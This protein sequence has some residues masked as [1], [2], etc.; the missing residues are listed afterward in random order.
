MGKLIPNHRYQQTCNHLSIL[1]IG[2]THP[3]PF[4][5]TAQRL[6]HV[7]LRVLQDIQEGKAAEADYTAIMDDYYVYLT[8][9]AMA[10]LSQSKVPDLSRYA[11]ELL[12]SQTKRE[13]VEA[14]LM[15]E[16]DLEE[17]HKVFSIP[18]ECLEIY[19]DLFFDTRYAFFSK[20]DIIEY[21][22]QYPC[23]YG[24]DLKL[25]CYHHGAAYV[26]YQFAN[27]VPLSEGQR[28]IIKKL[29]ASGA[30]KAMEADFNKIN[31]SISKAAM[32]WSKQTMDAFKTI[33]D[34]DGGED[35]KSFDS[36]LLDRTLEEEP[37]Y[38]GF[39]FVDPDDETLTIE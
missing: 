21:V 25:R 15:V 13:L 30:Y 9:D 33:R 5:K 32:T 37:S 23:E 1:G 35:T 14:L 34:T 7:A 12:E 29:F 6:M 8:E 19:R 27:E 39:G 4:V 17:I 36:Y 3:D 22:N 28:Q 26:Y 11:F 2:A 16:T 24:K 20:L 18:N 31:S 10:P 38:E